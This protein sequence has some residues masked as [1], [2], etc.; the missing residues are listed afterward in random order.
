ME[1]HDVTSSAITRVG[2]DSASMTLSVEWKGAGLYHYFDVS[3]ASFLSL[4]SASSVGNYVSTV[5]KPNHRYS[6][7]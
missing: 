4:K 5:I 2:Y 7:A 6:K 1:W 3:E